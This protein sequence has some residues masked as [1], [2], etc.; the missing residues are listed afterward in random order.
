MFGTGSSSRA[1]PA[2]TH[3]AAPARY[4]ACLTPA[5]ESCAAKHSLMYVYLLATAAA[6]L[7]AVR[8][9]AGVDV[10]DAF[11]PDQRPR[12]R[13]RCESNE[14]SEEAVAQSASRAAVAHCYRL[15]PWQGGGAPYFIRRIFFFLRRPFWPCWSIP[16]RH[17]ARSA[18]RGHHFFSF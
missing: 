14:R 9:V 12:H 2:A 3:L 1:R 7:S 17:A 13:S 18:P 10:G 4:T 11:Q 16:V 8:G 5:L 15:F 6:F